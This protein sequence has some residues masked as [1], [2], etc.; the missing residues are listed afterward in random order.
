[1]LNALSAT[2]AVLDEVLPDQLPPPLLQS[3]GRDAVGGIPN[4]RI[5]QNAVVA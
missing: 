5:L 2:A 4:H 3:D 1:M